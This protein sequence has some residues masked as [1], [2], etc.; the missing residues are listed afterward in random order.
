MSDKEIKSDSGER[1][2]FACD[3]SSL[4]LLHRVGLLETTAAVYH[5][6]VT[7]SVLAELKRGGSAEDYRRFEQATICCPLPQ[8]AP[9]IDD[10]TSTDAEVIALCLSTGA[11]AV[12]SDDGSLLRCCRRAG[13]PHYCALS[14]LPLLV[15]DGY[16]APSQ[17]EEAFSALLMQGRYSSKVIAEGRDMLLRS[18]QKRYLE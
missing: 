13:L 8:A 11:D 9:T 17:A 4:I 7:P 16:L 10:L 14:L 3:T 12:L 1:R 5:L 15:E 18:I 2:S 6:L